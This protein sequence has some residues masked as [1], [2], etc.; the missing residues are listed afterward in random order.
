MEKKAVIVKGSF[1]WV[2]H[3][4][5]FLSWDW[6]SQQIWEEVP[7]AWGDLEG[8]W[9]EMGVLGLQSYEGRIR[10]WQEREGASHEE[11]KG[12]LIGFCQ[13]SWCEDVRFFDLPFEDREKV[14]GESPLNEIT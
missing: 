9:N 13:W 14:W 6:F 4:M 7:F 3:P 5:E 8:I 12:L 1:H 2:L 11:L 10:S